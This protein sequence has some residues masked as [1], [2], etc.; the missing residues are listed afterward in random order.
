MVGNRTLG[1]QPTHATLG[2]IHQRHHLDHLEPFR[3]GDVDRLEQRPSGGCRV[4]DDRNPP[5]RAYRSHQ[6][7]TGP[8]VLGRLADG[9]RRQVP[10]ILSRHESGGEGDGVGADRHPPHCGHPVVEHLQDGA[11]DERGAEPVEGRLAGVDVPRAR[12][13]RPQRERAFRPHGVGSQVFHES[14][15]SRRD[16]AVRHGDEDAT[17]RSQRHGFRLPAVAPRRHPRSVTHW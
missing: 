4:L 1:Q 2:A 11:A 3:D 6:P 7:P 14:G 9:E 12:L 15:A 17:P 16:D 13:P 8:V 5:P 10:S